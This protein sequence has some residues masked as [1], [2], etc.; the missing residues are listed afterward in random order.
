MFLYNFTFFMS[1]QMSKKR[2]MD[3]TCEDRQLHCRC[4][5][6]NDTTRMMIQCDFCDVW[7]HPQC[8]G[9]DEDEAEN[10]SYWNCP[11]CVEIMSE[12][13]ALSRKGDFLI[14]KIGYWGSI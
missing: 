8:V 6:A 2:K 10:I 3:T 13:P 12:N 7:F 9:L 5:A 11:G 1:L 14:L 4:K